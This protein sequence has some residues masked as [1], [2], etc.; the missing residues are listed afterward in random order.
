MARRY[1]VFFVSGREPWI[2]ESSGLPVELVAPGG[3]W[4]VERFDYKNDPAAKVVEMY[5]R[6]QA[7][8]NRDNIETIED[9]K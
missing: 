6:G 9:F 5:S 3:W 1:I 7:W 4:P 2:V 8:I